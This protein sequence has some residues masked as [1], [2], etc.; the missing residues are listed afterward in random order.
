MINE[1]N[2]R[3][4]NINYKLLQFHTN[5]LKLKKETMDLIENTESKDNSIIIG[6]FG[7]LGCFLITQL[8]KN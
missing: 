6:I 8:R 2:E 1:I 3:V 4:G 5:N 7:M